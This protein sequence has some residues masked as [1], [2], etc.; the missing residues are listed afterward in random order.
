M[1]KENTWAQLPK[2]TCSHCQQN[3]NSPIAG[4]HRSINRL[5]A[6]ADERSR[7]LLVGFLAS[8]T[9]AVAFL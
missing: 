1:D 6:L 7:R 9:A 4:Q 8:N 5:V 2:C 3:P